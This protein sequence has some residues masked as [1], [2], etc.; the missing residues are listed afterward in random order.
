MPKRKIRPGIMVAGAPRSGSTILSKVLA[1]SPTIGYVE[2]PFNWQTGM[3][4]T[5]GAADGP[6]VGEI[7]KCMIT[8]NWGEAN[9]GEFAGMIGGSGTG[10][11]YLLTPRASGMLLDL[12]RAQS[13]VMKAGAATIPMEGES[14]LTIAKLT[15]PPAPKKYS[16]KARQK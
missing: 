6:R 8:G 13:V 12:A 5:G 14:E 2:E 10:G 7:L 4:G 1:L 16:A 3:I 15:R 9:S 11:G